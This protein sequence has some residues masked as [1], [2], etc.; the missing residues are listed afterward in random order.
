VLDRVLEGEDATLG[1]GLVSDVAVLL[2]HADHHALSRVTIFN[3]NR[4]R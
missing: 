3:V 2:A 4:Q 1:L